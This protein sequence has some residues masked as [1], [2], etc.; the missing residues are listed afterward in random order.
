MNS[1]RVIRTHSATCLGV[2][3][4]AMA[5]GLF[6][7]L[8]AD[9]PAPA[10]AG[11][12]DLDAFTFV[13]IMYD[14]VGGFGEAYYQYEGRVWQRWETDFPRAETNLLFRLNQL[15]SMK[16]NPE[17]LVL[18][19]TDDR[20]RDYPFI[21]MSDVGWQQLTQ[22]ER[23]SLEAYLEAGGFLWID[24]F[25]GEA[26]WDNWTVNF[27]GLGDN[28]QWRPV[29]D[30]HPLMSTIYR[31]P[32]CPQIPAR[33]FYEQTGRAW[34]PPQIHRSPSGGTAGVN[35][36]HLMGLFDV[37]DRLLAIA[38]HNTDIADGWEREGES[39]EF[40]ERF[41]INSYA[42]SINVLMYAMTH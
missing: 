4:L 36:V 26:E 6:G 28:W 29:S 13:R 20:L 39:R 33:I 30:T 27:Q 25:W 40:F 23:V 17:P 21:F 31:L 12:R 35:Q 42:F 15:T 37:N 2:C 19:L 14:S 34:D 16:V 38:T 32:E 8:R 22:P 10:A 41:S 5:W 9:A 24:D 11:N 18:R 1:Y 3:V 7:W